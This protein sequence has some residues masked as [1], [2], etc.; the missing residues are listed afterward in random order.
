MK[1]GVSDPLV[2]VAE[3]EDKTL[4]EGYG[5]VSEK[6]PSQNIVHQNMIKRFVP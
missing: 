4:E 5:T 3:F 1:V 6:Q 2:N